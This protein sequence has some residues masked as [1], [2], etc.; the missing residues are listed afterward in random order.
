V[1]SEPAEIPASAYRLQLNQ[2]F[3]FAQATEL[4]DYFNDLGVS[5]CY[6]SPFLM[7]QP[8]SLHGYDVT[9]H[10]RL[11]PEIGSREDFDRFSDQLKRRGM[12]IVAD[13]V[14]NHMCIAGPSNLWWWDVLENGPSSP[15]ARFFDIDWNPPKPDLVDKV[16]LPILGDQY[17]RVLEDQRITVVYDRGAFA[18]AVQ[19]RALP[20]APRSWAVV[21]EPALAEL[22]E[23]LGDG[24][25]HVLELESI[26]TALSHLPP[27]QETDETKIRERQREK[28]VIRKR[29]AALADSSLDARRAIE[30]SRQQINGTKG[31]P[32]S[33]DRLE[34][35]LAQQSYRLSFWGVAAAEINYRR[36]F[37]I[38][39]LAAIRVE[40]PEVFTA[41]HQLLFDLIK[42]G[43]IAGLRVDHPDGLFDPAE[44]FRRLQAGCMAATNSERPFFV[45]GEKILMGNEQL[46]ADW[47]IEGTTGYDFLNSLN[48]LYVDRSRRRAFHHLYAALTGWSQPYEDLIYES[49]KL[50]LYTAMSGELNV[51]AGKLDRISEQHRWSRDFT[52]ESLRHTL[53]EIIACFPIYRT[54]LTGNAPRPDAEDERHIR[55]AISRA[56]RRNQ[57][58]NESIFDFIQS[59][60]LLEDPEGI[61]DAQRG[62]R[63]LFVMRL[64]QFTSPVMAKG[65]ED[66]AFYRYYPLASLNEVGGDPQQFGV[67]PATFHARNLQR[68]KSWPNSLLATSTHDTKRSEDARARINVLTEVPGEW[69]RAWR[70]WRS[71][72]LTHKTSVGGVEAPGAN[73][74]Y[75]FYQSL[76]SIWPMNPDREEHT[77]LVARLQTYMRKALREAKQHSNWISPQIDYEEAVANFVEATLDPVPDNRFLCDFAAFARGIARAGIWNSLSQTLLKICSP[78]VPD[79]YQG[80][81]LW[82]F[83]LVD[84]DNRHPIDYAPRRCMLKKLREL[85]AN[86]VPEMVKQLIRESADGAIKLFVTSRLLRFRRSNQALFSKGTY[87]PLR[88]AGGRQNHAVA[89]TRMLR[90]HTVIA[91]A[92]RF[93]M[94]LRADKEAPV[95]PEVWGDTVL[96]VRKE[97]NARLF[98]DVLT[99]ST[100]HVEKRNGRLAL[101]LAEV[102]GHLPIA[103]LESVE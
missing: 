18:V 90:R 84:P 75:L 35:L 102:F 73:E 7:A 30:N 96:Q 86:G 14:A 39:E 71:L 23:K 9:D 64:Q 2:E 16:L 21:L 68:L 78:G 98:R 20:L 47:E 81:E 92:G 37:D 27:N 58:I 42:E 99:G 38:N 79:F 59:V 36:F 57:S 34:D 87:A 41:V 11:N 32:R 70:S 52:L 55:F 22:K 26:L 5:H 44:Y 56:K 3:T 10:S 43:R 65:L 88:A 67:L 50:L 33:F 83:S 74:E 69:Y 66:T 24:D 31:I 15:Y 97:L 4:V 17:G 62:E 60:L 89:L 82:D 54:Y 93:F 101:N 72:N 53:R 29:L 49:K 95:G 12:G 46:R 61:D 85:E 40:D 1:R 94:G 28:E 45:V 77:E 51:L 103:L 80:S 91:A 6:L 76:L 63:R 100:V 25:E 13:V 8:G 48:G 19:E